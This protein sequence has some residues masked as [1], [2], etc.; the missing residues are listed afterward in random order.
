[1]ASGGE[2]RVAALNTLGMRADW[3]V[4][5]L[6]FQAGCRELDADIITLQETIF[7]D[8]ADQAAEMLDP[9]YHLAQQQHREPDGQGITTASRWPFGQVF[10]V[11]FHLTMAAF[12]TRARDAK[13]VAARFPSALVPDLAEGARRQG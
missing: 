6:V 10:E 5:R 8:H 2:L 1:M 4:R 13:R 12:P 11:D 9:G 7:H 3:P